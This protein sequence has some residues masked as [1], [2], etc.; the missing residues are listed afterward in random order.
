MSLCLDWC[1]HQAGVNVMT[2]QDQPIVDREVSAVRTQAVLAS[3]IERLTK[4][5]IAW[6]QTCADYWSAANLY[7][8]LRNLSDAELHR[9]GLSRDT[10]ARDVCQSCD[11]T[12]HKTG[13][14]SPDAQVAH[15]GGVGKARTAQSS[16]ETGRGRYPRQWTEWVSC[17]GQG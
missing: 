10:V 15:L 7:E 8:S 3:S 5:V 14:K 2:L 1:W 4:V 17:R 9:R 16:G 11:R 6:V 12:A 13:P